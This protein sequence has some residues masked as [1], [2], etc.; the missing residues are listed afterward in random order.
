MRSCHN[1]RVSIDEMAP[2]DLTWVVNS[3]A[4]WMRAHQ[5]VDKHPELD[6][7]DV[8]HVLSTLHETPSQR[9]RRSLA[10]ARLRPRAR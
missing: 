6:A 9:V 4:R 2:D 8:Y 5:I 10:H 7:G 3:E 1:L